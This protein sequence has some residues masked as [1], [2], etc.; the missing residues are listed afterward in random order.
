VSYS[1]IA[2]FSPGAFDS[3]LVIALMQAQLYRHVPRALVTRPTPGF[4]MPIAEWLRRPLREWA[5]A[6]LDPVRIRREGILD[7]APDRR[8]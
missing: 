4:G 5:E 8:P 7:P 2:R 3:S 6:L 1:I